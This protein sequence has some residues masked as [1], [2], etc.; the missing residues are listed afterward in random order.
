MLQRSVRQFA[1]LV[2]HCPRLVVLSWPIVSVGTSCATV[3]RYLPEYKSKEEMRRHLRELLKT[4]IT[5][6]NL[7]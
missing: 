3:G 5:G 6:F 4:D 2:F 1:G 7:A